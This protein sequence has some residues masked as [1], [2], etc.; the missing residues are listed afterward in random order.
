MSIKRPL[1][2]LLFLLLVGTLPAVATE[3]PMQQHHHAGHMHGGPDDRKLVMFPP[4][5]ITQQLKNMRD[6]MEALDG[7]LRALAAD[8]Y[9]GAAAIANTRLGL[10]SPSAVGC[11]PLPQGAPRPAKG[12]MEEMMGLYMPEDMRALGV[13]MHSAASDFATAA[14]EAKGKADP[15]IAYQALSQVTAHC[16]ACHAA[17]RVH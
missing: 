15:K 4:E 12:S 10:D 13:A 5:M 14:L 16:T 11:K 6:H 17:F 7:I 2:S 8:D 1:L 9:A 3:L